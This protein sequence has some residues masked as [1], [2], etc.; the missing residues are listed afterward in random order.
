MDIYKTTGGR[1]WEEFIRKHKPAIGR[2]LLE[3]LEEQQLLA[4]VRAVMNK[5]D[6]QL[7]TDFYLTWQS[8]DKNLSIGVLLL[9]SP[10]MYVQVG[11]R[12]FL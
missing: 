11:Q 1:G 7:E 9:N 3:K 10:Y 12:I 4:R 6:L 5:R 2:T 8:S